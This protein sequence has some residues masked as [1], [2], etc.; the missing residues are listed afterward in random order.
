M[1][2]LGFTSCGL[3][4]RALRVPRARARARHTGWLVGRGATRGSLIKL[5]SFGCARRAL[6]RTLAE[7]RRRYK[8]SQTRVAAAMSTSQP[9]LARL[10]TTAADTK[11]STVERQTAISA[12]A[13]TAGSLILGLEH[14]SSATDDTHLG[15]GYS[16]CC[17][18]QIP[19]LS[20][21]SLKPC[22]TRQTGPSSG[23]PSGR[24]GLLITPHAR[25][26]D[27]PVVELQVAHCR[28]SLGVLACQAALPRLVAVGRGVGV[29]VGG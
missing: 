17:L 26:F 25:E 9:T 24:G 28:W 18:P 10:E 4:S 12:R 15:S 2:A 14:P 29:G 27:C 19:P 7:Q 23:S 21:P 3:L 13:Q 22:D 20:S 16:L 6:L 8:L 11:L 1:R 5:C